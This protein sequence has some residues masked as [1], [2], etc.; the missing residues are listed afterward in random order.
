MLRSL[1]RKPF[2]H[3]CLNT[4][5]RLRSFV[6]IST[7]VISFISFSLAIIIAF[8]I[9]QEVIE[10]RAREMSRSISR[11]AF[12]TLYLLM[13]KG[14]TS[15]ELDDVLAVTAGTEEETEY[16]VKLYRND[17]TATDS[18][19]KT[20]LERGV[21]VNNNKGFQ[22]LDIYPVEAKKVCLKCHYK[23]K[24]G[25]ILAAVSVQQDI[26]PTI[27]GIKKKFIFYFFLL[28]P[29]PFILT[30]IIANILNARI[31][32][33][34][35]LFHQKIQNVSSIEDLAK[36]ETN[37]IN[38]GFAEFDNMLLDIN[39]FVKRIKNVAVD[40]NLLERELLERKLANKEMESFIYSISHDLR[41]PVRAMSGFAKIINEDYAGKLDAKGEDYLARILKGSEKATQLIDDL[42]RLSKISREEIERSEVNLSDKASEIVKELR[43]MD[44]GRN[45][46][47]IVQEG[48]TASVDPRL[49]ELALSNLLSNAW[50]F[51]SKTENARIEFR[52]IQRDGETVYY[53]KDNGVG[54]EPTYADKMFWPFHR[55]HSEE[56]F[57]GT[58][59]GLA[60]V[61]RVIRRHGGKVWAEGE[62]GKG[63]TIYFTLGR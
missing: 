17:G 18:D 40:K 38:I 46:E 56:E 25:N 44:R 23:E 41:A 30:V 4:Q 19:I 31:I 5:Y 20:V 26:G 60:I 14:W 28:S 2:L 37:S 42:L 61:D 43:E 33:A 49:I 34:T 7:F 6:C 13:Q 59:I 29:L 3:T 35:A 62:V 15:K 50:K 21:V 55:L 39:N 57:E 1:V 12:N 24:L 32:K 48:L 58:G 9:Y 11:Q 36:L 16:Q 8:T 54:F 52:T 51:T 47:V 45:V 10:H 22:L 63:A 27:K 53:V